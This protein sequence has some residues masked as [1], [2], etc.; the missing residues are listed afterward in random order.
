MHL[1]LLKQI[2]FSVCCLS[3]LALRGTDA[4]QKAIGFSRRSFPDI[5]D[6]SALLDELRK[7]KQAGVLGGHKP[8]KGRVSQGHTATAFGE[9]V[10]SQRHFP[11]LAYLAS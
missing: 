10:A 11:K 7:A 6:A 9:E 2:L 4:S 8:S 5:S 1:M 3:S